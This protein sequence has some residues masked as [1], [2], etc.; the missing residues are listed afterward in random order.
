MRSLKYNKSK[1]T[2]HIFYNNLQ[3]VLIHIKS[4]LKWNKY[5]SI[6]FLK[7]YTIVPITDIWQYS[8]RRLRLLLIRELPTYLLVRIF[9]NSTSPSQFHNMYKWCIGCNLII[10]CEMWTLS[11]IYWFSKV[12]LS[13]NFIYLIH[14]EII[15][16]PFNYCIAFLFN[17]LLHNSY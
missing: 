4:Y 5:S 17:M 7:T 14:I 12:F 10:T 15:L 16:I 8:I 11:E 13:L 6:V 1:I 2:M 3:N 9:W